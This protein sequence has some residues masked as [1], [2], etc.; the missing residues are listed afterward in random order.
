MK[1]V[2]FGIAL[3]VA[4]IMGSCAG[5]KTEAPENDTLVVEEVVQDSACTDS[6]VNDSV[7]EVV[8]EPAE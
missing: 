1:K 8:E 4:C 3:F 2:I 6:I 5:N 7:P